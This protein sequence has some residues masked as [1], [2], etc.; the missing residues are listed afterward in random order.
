MMALSDIHP[1]EQDSRGIGFTPVLLRFHGRFTP[2]QG[3]LWYTVGDSAGFFSPYVVV[4]DSWRRM[5]W[6]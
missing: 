4:A 5:T 3:P 2:N 1:Q 6:P